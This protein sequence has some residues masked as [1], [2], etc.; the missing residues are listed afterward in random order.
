MF[1]HPSPGA[2]IT[3]GPTPTNPTIPNTKIIVSAT[4]PSNSPQAPAAVPGAGVRCS[5]PSG[6]SRPA[7]T[8]VEAVQVGLAR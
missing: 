5:S 4:F 3:Q 6:C 8:A 1:L 7:A 2:E